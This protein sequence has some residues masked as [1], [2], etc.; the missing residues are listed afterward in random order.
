[1]SRVTKQELNAAPEAAVTVTFLQ[2]TAC[3]SGIRAYTTWKSN[4]A[5]N[6]IVTV[7]SLMQPAGLW[8]AS[9]QRVVDN[10]GV[11]I[12]APDKLLFSRCG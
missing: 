8:Q 4:K 7:F 2:V 10:W 3:P 6:L 5:S 11:L 1:M 9:S 12:T